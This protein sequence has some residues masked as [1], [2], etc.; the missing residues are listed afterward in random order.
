MIV[1]VKVLDKQNIIRFSH[2]YDRHKKVD[3][4]KIKDELRVKFP[5]PEFRLEVK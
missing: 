2:E 4:N 1:E 5:E 3:L